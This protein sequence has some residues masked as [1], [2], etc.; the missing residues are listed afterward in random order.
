MAGTDLTGF[1]S[2]YIASRERLPI[3][4]CLAD[5]GLDAVLADYAG[6]AFIS[7]QANPSASARA[8]RECLIS[9]PEATAVG[10]IDRK[11]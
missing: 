7:P 4:E 10:Q 3:R 9:Q 11:Q 5:T 2:R 6:E 8:I 1:F